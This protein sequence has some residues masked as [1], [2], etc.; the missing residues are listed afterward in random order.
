[1][2]PSVMFSIVDDKAGPQRLPEGQSAHA[3]HFKHERG[4]V[5]F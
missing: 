3:L 5:E 1:M 2:D 4:D